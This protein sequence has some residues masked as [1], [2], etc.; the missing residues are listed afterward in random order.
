[1]VPHGAGLHWGMPVFSCFILMPVAILWI[2][3]ALLK[4]MYENNL[5]P[6]CSTKGCGR[7]FRKRDLLGERYALNGDCG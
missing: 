1:M 4:A 5:G 3:N 2:L 6:E 7:S